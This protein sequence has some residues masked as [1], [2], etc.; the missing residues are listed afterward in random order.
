VDEL[1]GLQ[2]AV[3]C[4]AKLAKIENDYRVDGPQEPK[5]PVEKLLKL[6]GGDKAPFSRS[7]AGPADLLRTQLQQALGTVQALNDP[8]GVY[9]RMPFELGLR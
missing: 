5:S 8:Q 3:R 2:D 7:Q 9:A 6:L 4:A 1:G